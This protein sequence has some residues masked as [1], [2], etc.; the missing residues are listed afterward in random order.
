MN[1]D[2]CY[3]VRTE[4]RESMKSKIIL[5]FFVALCSFV[6]SVDC[7]AVE[8]HVEF[9]ESLTN[10]TSW[11]YGSNTKI[12]NEK[13]FYITGGDSLAVES[14]T[15]DFAITSVTVVAHRASENTDRKLYAVPMTVAGALE[16]RICDITPTGANS[17]EISCGWPK[18]SGVRKIGFKIAGES[19]N[20]YLLSAKILGVSIPYPPEDLEASRVGGRQLDIKWKNSDA[21]VGCK[22][23]IYKASWQDEYFETVCSC[24]F[25]KEGFENAGGNPK[26][27]G[28]LAESYPD[29]EG[30]MLIYL[31]T[32][33][34]GQIQISTADDKGVLKHKGFDDCALLHIDMTVRK[35]FSSEAKEEDSSIMTIGYEDPSGT[36]N[37]FATLNL[38]SEFKRELITLKGFPPNTPILFNATGNKTNHRVAIDEINFIKNYSPAG[39]RMELIREMDTCESKIRIVDLERNTDYIIKVTAFDV[40]GKESES[41]ELRVRTTSQND[42]GFYIR[43]Q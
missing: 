42:A 38:E 37:V 6:F 14:P 3:T 41:A 39:E 30:S 17:T 29:F 26:K 34:I 22:V 33:T 32:N 20:V 23:L 4:R 10:E 5:I 7:R 25:D 21:V 28:N 27:I 9:N 31:P 18:E 12:S 35:Y 11:V 36:T 16:D 15:F 2:L 1:I 43:V 19:G 8:I 24:D 40:R 13:G